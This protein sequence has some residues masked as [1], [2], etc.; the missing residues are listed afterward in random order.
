MSG[1]SYKGRRNPFNPVAPLA[2][3]GVVAFDQVNNVIIVWEWTGGNPPSWGLFQDDGSG[4]V[5]VDTVP[6]DEDNSVYVPIDGDMYY[7]V[8]L[9]YSGNPY[10][11]PSIEVTSPF[12]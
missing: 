9:D 3:Y 11:T 12:P 6:G 5:Q 2:D 10:G 8:G 1:H 7:V 4:P